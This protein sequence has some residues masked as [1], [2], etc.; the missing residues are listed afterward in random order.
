MESMAWGA[1]MGL[2]TA[3]LKLKAAGMPATA[4]QTAAVTRLAG[5]QSGV[6]VV[7]K[8]QFHPHSRADDFLPKAAGLR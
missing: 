2:A 3:A 4:K 6:L 7:A 5:W 8:N 1:R